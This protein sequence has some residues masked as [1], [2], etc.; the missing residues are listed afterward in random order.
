VDYGSKPSWLLI[1]HRDAFAANMDADAFLDPRT[2]RPLP[3]A[4]RRAV[5]EALTERNRAK[6]RK[7]ASR[8][9]PNASRRTG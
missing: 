2:D 5:A 9:T 8:S 6:T 1:K 4:K 7:P 3:K